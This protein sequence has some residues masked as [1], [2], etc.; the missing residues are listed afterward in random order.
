MT[1][2]KK[3]FLPLTS[4]DICR[5]Y[6]LL[7]KEGLVSFPKNSSSEDRIDSLVS[8]ING[9][10]FGEK[11]YKS[12][13]EKIVA[14]LYFL[15]KNHPFVDGNKRTAVLTFLV[16]SKMNGLDKNLEDY[17]LDALAI[18]LEGLQ[19]KNHQFVIKYISEKIFF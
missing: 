19:E 2:G 3:Q 15:I 10:N 12:N 18:F 5:I 1:K 14:Y 9:S 7:Y 11:N 13:A 6:N 17:D 8:N 4:K 16:L